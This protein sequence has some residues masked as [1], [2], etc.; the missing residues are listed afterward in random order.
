MP[1]CNHLLSTDSKLY[2]YNSNNTLQFHSVQ[3]IAT[4]RLN[5]QF[6]IDY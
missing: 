3:H 1:A 2:Y 4:K 5:I 6:N